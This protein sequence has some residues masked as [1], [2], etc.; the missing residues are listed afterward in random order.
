MPCM[1]K[2]GPRLLTSDDEDCHTLCTA[3]RVT[4]KGDPSLSC[5]TGQVTEGQAPRVTIEQK[6]LTSFTNMSF[7]S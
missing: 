6:H 7:S 3:K 1:G 5:P 4:E 2:E